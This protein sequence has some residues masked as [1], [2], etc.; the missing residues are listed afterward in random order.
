MRVGSA[1]LLWLP[2]QTRFL[3]GDA[4]DPP[5]DM[6]DWCLLLLPVATTRSL[7]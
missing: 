6:E 4:A 1:P 5:S 2:N 7:T 3:G